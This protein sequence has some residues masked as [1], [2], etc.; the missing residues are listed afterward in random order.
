MKKT[1]LILLTFLLSAISFAGDGHTDKVASFNEIVAPHKG[2][3][4]VVDFWN[5][6]CKACCV[7]M[8]DNE[9]LKNG[10][11]KSKDIVWI[12]VADESSPYEDYRYKIRYFKGT[13]YRLDKETI[14]K[15]CRELGITSYPAYVLVGKDGKYQLREDMKEQKGYINAIREELTSK[16]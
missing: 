13:H 16:P 5:T 8:G 1:V 15:I 4:V 11:L 2:K 9:Y 10:K 12:Y 3:V 7:A 14:T 6:W